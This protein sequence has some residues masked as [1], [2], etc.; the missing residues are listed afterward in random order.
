LHENRVAI[1]AW[2]DSLPGH[3]RRRLIGAQAVVKRWRKTTQPTERKP[4]DL[5][6][7]ALRGDDLFRVWKCYRPIRHCRYGKPHSPR[8]RFKK[9]KLR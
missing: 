8:S 5:E 6:Q 3:R 2:R 9:N 1:T 4:T 7:R